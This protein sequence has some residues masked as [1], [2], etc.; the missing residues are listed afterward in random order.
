MLLVLCKIGVLVAVFLFS[1]LLIKRLL[2]PYQEYR[3]YKQQGV[4]FNDKEGFSVTRDPLLRKR[5][6]LLHKNEWPLTQM[7]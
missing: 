7:V 4:I 3:F 5:L 2:L 1:I 6:T